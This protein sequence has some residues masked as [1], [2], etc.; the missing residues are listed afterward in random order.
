[1]LH[2]REVAGFVAVHKVLDTVEP[3]LP[4]HDSVAVWVPPPQSL[5]QVLNA[6]SFQEYVGQA[7]KPVQA[8]VVAGFV[9]VQKES[10]TTTLLLF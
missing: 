10:A 5:V 6:E 9:P 2:D 3:V 1:V 7:D 4:T 8:V